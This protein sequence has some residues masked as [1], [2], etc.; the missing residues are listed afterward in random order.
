MARWAFAELGAGAFAGFDAVCAIPLQSTR[1][2]ARQYD[3]ATLLAA[4][5][6]NCTG[7]PLRHWLRR[8]KATAR[9][10]DLSDA[11]RA[12]NVWRAFEAKAEAQGK[13]ILLVDDVLTTGATGNAA[14]HALYEAGATRVELLTLARARKN[15]V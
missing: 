13:V 10:V 7:V 15:A 4:E 9:Q 6:A 14:A 8:H 11:Q 12:L 2:W 1:F 3:Q 5:W